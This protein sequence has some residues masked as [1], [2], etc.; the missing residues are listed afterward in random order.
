MRKY[1]LC[2]FKNRLPKISLAPTAL[3]GVLVLS[4][5]NLKIHRSISTSAK[6]G[7]QILTRAG[8]YYLD[9]PARRAG[10]VLHFVSIADKERLTVMARNAPTCAHS[11]CWN[12]VRFEVK[13][14][15]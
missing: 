2:G 12:Y 10:N 7:R 14:T 11:F 4:M 6:S 5:Y 1:K 15:A 3:A 9:L 13:I 8:N